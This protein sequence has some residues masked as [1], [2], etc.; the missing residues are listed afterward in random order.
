ME[1]QNNDASDI[2]VDSEGN[3]VPTET[4]FSSEQQK[5]WF[6]RLALAVFVIIVVTATLLIN[7][8]SLGS[9]EDGP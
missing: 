7:S 4:F 8:I 6:L 9:T 1:A 5:Q 3:P 2:T